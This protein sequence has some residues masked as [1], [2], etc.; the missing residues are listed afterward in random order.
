ME[1][2]LQVADQVIE[3]AVKEKEEK[4]V[5]AKGQQRN[6]RKVPK[7]LRNTKRIKEPTSEKNL[8]TAA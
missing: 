7:R 6:Q 5:K 2:Q 4:P 8:M 1:K 3:E